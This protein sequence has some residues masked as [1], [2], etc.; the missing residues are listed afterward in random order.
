M[1]ISHK[2]RDT[3]AEKQSYVCDRFTGH[4]KAHQPPLPGSPVYVFPVMLPA[5]SGYC[6]PRT[7]D[8]A[9]TL[10]G[11]CRPRF[12]GCSCRGRR[13]RHVRPGRGDGAILWSFARGGSVTGGAAVAGRSVYWGSGYCGTA[14]IGSA[15][16]T[17]NN[18]VY[19]F[20]LGR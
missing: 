8:T 12:S 2:A 16:P 9:G 19:A 13:H 7:P 10:S 5:P 17:N 20:G 4:G 18:K 1:R 15:P 11:K 3:A 14:C 6:G